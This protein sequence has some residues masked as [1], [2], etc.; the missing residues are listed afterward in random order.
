MKSV[1]EVMAIGRKFEEAAQKAIRMLSI[2]LHGLVGNNL[3]FNDVEKELKKP[4]D[5]RL[6]VIVEALKKGISIDKIYDLTKIDKWFLHKIKNV[7]ETEKELLKY[8]I[9]NVPQ[10]LLKSAKQNGFSDFQIA[11]ILFKNDTK[12]I[13][14]KLLEVRNLRK[15]HNIMPVVKQIDTLAAEYPAKTNYL[16]LTYNGEQDDIQFGDKNSVIVLGS[17]AYRIGSS[18]EFDWCCVNAVLTLKKSG[19]SAIMINCN[20]ETVS[21]DYDVCDKL[22]FEELSFERVLDIYEKE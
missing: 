5:K 14:Q 12:N 22:Y 7:V 1:G 18:V 6:L 9:K 2:N 13:E 17:G 4:T 15:L 3:A 20:P 21:T 19:Y 10:D 16:Y 8:D 11:R